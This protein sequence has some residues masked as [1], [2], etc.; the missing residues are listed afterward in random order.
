VGVAE[1]DVAGDLELVVIGAGHQGV[2][3]A[4]RRLSSTKKVVAAFQVTVAV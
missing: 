3:K 4:L 2:G 1:V